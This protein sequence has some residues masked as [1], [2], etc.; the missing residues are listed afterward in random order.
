[1]DALSTF[2]E[3]YPEGTASRSTI[4]TAL[5]RIEETAETIRQAEEDD[6]QSEPDYDPYDGYA[7]G[8]GSGERSI[9]DDVHQ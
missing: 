8:A 2:H 1:V 4:M 3:A 5:S 6:S 9:F 7:Y